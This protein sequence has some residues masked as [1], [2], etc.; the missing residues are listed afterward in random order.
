MSRKEGTS[1][2]STKFRGGGNPGRGGRQNAEADL[3][4]G[5]ICQTGKTWV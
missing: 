4:L 2:I 5:N 3:C 1:R